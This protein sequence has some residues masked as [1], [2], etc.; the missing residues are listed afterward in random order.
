MTLKLNLE[1]LLKPF[2]ENLKPSLS[3]PKGVEISSF[4]T[5]LKQVFE[6]ESLSIKVHEAHA[7]NHLPHAELSY[8][9]KAS[10][11]PA[12]FY[13]FI[14]QPSA[15]KLLEKF[16]GSKTAFNDERLVKG[17][18]GYLVTNGIQTLNES[19]IFASSTFYL[20]EH[21]ELQEA[22]QAVKVEVLLD[23]SYPLVFDLYFPESFI[24]SFHEHFANMT[25]DHYN[26]ISFVTKL[27]IGQTKLTSEQFRSL[28]VSD[29]L[30]LDESLFMPDQNKGLGRLSLN[31]R[32]FAQVRINHNTIKFLDFNP[33]PDESYMEQNQEA[34]L[35]NLSEIS[36]DLQVE[37]ARITMS[38]SDLE[39]LTTGQ[40]IEF[41]KDQ[42]TSCYLTLQ[43][44][45]VAKGEL[46]KVGEQMA[47]LIEELKNG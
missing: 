8:F 35:K 40:T 24:D 25:K 47:F 36:L 17:A 42:A 30:V 4:E 38:F 1:H 31:D 32:S 45:R 14:Y 7:K 16:F 37:F 26:Q 12:G 6:T 39:K 2:T 18:L 19:Q 28:K 41:S 29:A 15:S 27:L 33:L 44:Q 34:P 3:L 23:E 13:L 21:L 22:F 5:I 11:S 46:V 20:A 10:F 9:I 43:G